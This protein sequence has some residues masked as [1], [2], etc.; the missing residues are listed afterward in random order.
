MNGQTLFVKL[1]LSS[2][3]KASHFLLFLMCTLCFGASSWAQSFS[4]YVSPAGNDTNA[5]TLA[6]PW[7]TIQHALNTVTVAGDTIYV[8]AGVYNERVTFPH[9]GNSNGGPI[10]LQ[11]YPGETAVIDGTGVTIGTT[12]YAYGLVDIVSQSYITVSGM[13]IRNFKTTNHDRVPAGIHVEGSGTNLQFL[14]NY[15]HGIYNT[16]SSPRHNGSCPSHSPN[17]F[18]LIVAGTSGTSPIINLTIS[19]NTLTDLIT[20]CSESMTTN[21]NTQ[22]FTITNNTVHDNSNIGIAALGGEGVASSHD[23]AKNG[24]ISGN[25]IYNIT[26]SSQVGHAW[27]VYGSNCVCADGIY[28][29]GSDTV[30]VERN[31]VHNVDWGIETTGEKSGQNTTNIIIRSNLFYS[32][33]AAGEGVGGQ[34]NPGGASNITSVNNTFYNNDTTGQGNGTLSLGASISGYV[35]FKNNIVDASSGGLTVTGQTGTSGLSFDYNLYFNG[36]SPFTEAHSLNAN[37]QFVSTTRPDLHVASGSPAVNAGINLG[38]SIVGTLDFAGNAR[39]QGTNIDI[40]AY[41]Q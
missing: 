33:N 39:V 15:I 18:G 27:D 28:L 7:K 40:G 35:V 19:G 23:Q 41:E 1:L 24:V 11:N 34:G 29:D 26:S 8:R 36:T 16:G 31:V 2:V 30:T 21:G 17:A 22:N 25:T 5:G 14:N 4:F 13:E 20:G 6:S 38:A 10:T 32:N 9:S 12:G 37:P 3:R